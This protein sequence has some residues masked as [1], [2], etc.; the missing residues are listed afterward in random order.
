MSR[1]FCYKMQNSKCKMQNY[2]ISFGNIFFIIRE[3]DTYILHSA[4]CILHYSS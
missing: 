4:F 3:A 1:A 2:G